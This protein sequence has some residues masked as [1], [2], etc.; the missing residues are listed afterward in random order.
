M[1]IYLARHG[2][3]TGDIEDRYGGD[4]DDHLT[5]LG[6]KQAGTLAD[7][8]HNVGIEKIFSSPLFRAK[9]TADILSMRTGSS[10]EITENLRERNRYAVLTGMTKDGGTK[11]FPTLAEEVQVFTATIKG[12]EQFGHFESRIIEA[13]TDLLLKPFNAIALITHGGPLRVLANE[14]LGRAKL[15]EKMEDCGWAFILKNRDGS[16]TIKKTKGFLF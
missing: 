12:A 1:K 15:K 5:K 9:E 7:E 6:M 11:Q 10:V 14:V 4:Y 3:S 2:Q 13:F 16:L 8:L